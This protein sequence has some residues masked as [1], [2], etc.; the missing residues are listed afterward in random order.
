MKAVLEKNPDSKYTIS[1]KLWA[2]HQ[3][4]TEKNLDRGAGFTA[5][6]TDIEKPSKTIVS[7]YYKDG[8]ECLIPQNGKNPRLLT[9]KECAKLFEYPKSFQHAGSRTASYKQSPIVE[10]LAKAG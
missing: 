6:A 8:K 10:K 7:R 4:R 1:D 3:A 9:V 2:G 5:Y